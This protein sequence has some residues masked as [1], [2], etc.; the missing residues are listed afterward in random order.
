MNPLL[1]RTVAVAALSL[2]AAP[3]PGGPTRASAFP[4]AELATALFAGGCFW[5][6]EHPFDQLRGVAA[7]SV[8]YTGGHTKNPTY[9]E[10]SAGWTGH[11]EA[12][13]V[14]YDPA[15]VSYEKL[16]DAFWHSIDPLTPDGQ[17]CDLGSQYRTA[18]FYHD[19]AQ[20]RVA[21]ES[22]RQLETS[23]RFGRPVATAIQPASEFYRAE[24]YHQHYY[25]KNPV[26]YNLYRVG[27]GRDRR[28][29]ELWGAPAPAVPTQR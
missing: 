7:V 28:L 15:T 24:E 18:I 12:V 16:V 14:S 13:Q 26:R 27:C 10:V 23:A 29:A 25:R 17:F 8:G 9:E 21:E 2:F 5:S 6:M 20:R 19:S 11:L 4:R 1:W 3:R 22:K